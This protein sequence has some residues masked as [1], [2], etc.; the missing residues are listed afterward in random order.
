MARNTLETIRLTRKMFVL[1]RIQNDFNT[2][3]NTKEL[4][5]T[6]SVKMT[7]YNGIVTTNGIDVPGL[8]IVYVWGSP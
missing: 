8:N 7:E 3:P 6:P 1:V 4:P 2:T 5:R